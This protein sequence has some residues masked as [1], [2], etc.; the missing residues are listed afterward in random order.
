M[1]CVLIVYR[2]DFNLSEND[3]R[4]A[5]L[6]L[7]TGNRAEAQQMLKSLVQADLQDIHAWVWYVESLPTLNQKIR[8]LELC[9][10]YNPGNERV[11]KGL[12]VL[13]AHQAR[14]ADGDEQYIYGK[15]DTHQV[16]PHCGARIDRW[17]TICDNCGGSLV[18]RRFVLPRFDIRIQLPSLATL[19]R[20]LYSFTSYVA[21]IRNFKSWGLL[22]FV[23]PAIG[24]CLIGMWLVRP[25]A[26]KEEN[27]NALAI[28]ERAKVESIDVTIHPP[29]ELDTLTKEE[30]L[31]LR[32]GEVYRYPELLFSAYEPN[33]R[34]FGEI[35]DG[36]P[37][38]GIAGKFY[39]GQGEQSIEG[40]SDEARFIMNPYL[41]IAAD[42]CGGFDRTMVSEQLIQRPGFP[43]YCPVEDL[44]W[45]PENNYVE[46][47]YNASC[48]SQRNY[49]CFNLIAYNA[50]D[51]NLNYIYISYE[52]SVN[53][54]KANRPNQA[55]AIPQY[56]HQGDSCGYI[57]GCNN[58]SPATPELEG[59]S[60]V[61]MPARVEIWLWKEEP[62]SLEIS[63]DMIYVIRVR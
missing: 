62:E 18:S 26:Q 59:L 9:L 35:V 56:L 46:V 25:P 19:R 52:D 29:I 45:E 36:L 14:P 42:P 21:G 37:W 41:L 11:E 12:A 57:G 13:R 61:G 40:Q 47:T 27:K 34:V 60:I 22:V 49:S 2:E 53:I 39:Y 31:E 38:W 23:L 5:I 8:A 10:K 28:G 20:R 44:M 58:I 15:A 4:Q 16:C 50:R 48:V 54:S 6:L 3:I 24:L 30:V 7:K 51:F 55:I 32:I 33:S 1:G 43:F 17:A 63:P